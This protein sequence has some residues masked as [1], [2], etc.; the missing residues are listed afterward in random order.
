MT[1]VGDFAFEATRKY[2]QSIVFVDDEIYQD[3]PAKVV[4]FSKG[5]AVPAM[6]VFAGP[7][8]PTIV[9]DDKA[10]ADVAG[11]EDDIAAATP[12]FPKLLVESFARERMVCALYE[13]PKDFSTSAESEIFKLC[14]RAD[15]VILD[16]DFHKEPGR[17]VIQLVGGLATSG[18][19]TVP[20]HIR[21]FVIYTATQN[22]RHVAGELF[23]GLK[24]QDL[25]VE[26]DGDYKLNT[27]SSRIVVL[28]KPTAGRPQDQID[29]AEVAEANLANRIIAEFAAMHEGILSSIALHGL[30]S[31]RTNTKRILDKFQKEM[32]GAF[33]VHRGLIL[34]GDD[35]FDQIPELLAE[36]ALAI[37]AD[38]WISEEDS[39]ALAESVIDGRNIQTE[40]AANR[41]GA[42]G[43]VRAAVELLKKGPTRIRKTVDLTPDVLNP[44]HQELDPE[45]KST[46]ERLA[47]LYSSRTQYG[48]KRS[49]EF[50][51]IVRYEV[52]GQGAQ[53]AMCLMPL[54]DCVRLTKD[55]LYNFPF[56]KLRV[57]NDSQ[58]SKGIVIELPYGSGF[59]ELFC[60]GKPRDQLWLNR[61]K[62]GPAKMVEAEKR[63]NKFIFKGEDELE[64]E[65]IAQLKPSHAQRIAHEVSTSFARVGVLEAEWLRLKANGKTPPVGSSLENL[66]AECA[67]CEIFQ[68]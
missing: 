42:S 44:L 39:K 26:A 14:D 59:V 3:V 6:R 66:P 65:W 47:A 36:E 54:C 17:K 8:E 24:N 58:P 68:Q 38:N 63:G 34:P 9:K 25:S 62:A 19:S 50:G 22:L 27:G 55:K 33:L 4:Q 16:W 1:K 64:I 7:L 18:Q 48:D 49:L 29:A 5:T 12:F 52:D 67:R 40:W 51:T 45:R 10:P 60:M 30:A 15:V 21:L 23:E 37:I 32:D 56:W 20:H 57:D 2:L 53:Y 28:G 13:P 35:A 31:V 43:P 11:E 41:N 61:F 46:K